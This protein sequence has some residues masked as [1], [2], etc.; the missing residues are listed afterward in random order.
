MVG[1]DSAG[2]TVR[3]EGPTNNLTIDG[4]TL[5]VTGDAFNGDRLTIEQNNNAA[6]SMSVAIS[7]LR[8]IAAADLFTVIPS[9]LNSGSV[10]ASVAITSQSPPA[11]VTSMV[12]LVKN[13]GNARAA[14][15]TNTSI[16]QALMRI[17][18]GAEETTIY[19]EQVD[20]FK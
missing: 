11:L 7:D 3:S 15:T 12:D 18:E 6:A 4:V 17:P 19:I 10:K 20:G 8:N 9:G 5:S 2:K 14:I 1:Q 16:G 13:N